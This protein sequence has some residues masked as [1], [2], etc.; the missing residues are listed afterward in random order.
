M[1][2]L[3]KVKKADEENA[4]QTE[5]GKNLYLDRKY[6][7]ES[8]KSIVNI[9]EISRYQNPKNNL[10]DPTWRE[11]SI[12]STAIFTSP[13]HKIRSIVSNSAN[14]VFSISAT[15]GVFGDLTTSYDMGYLEDKL[16]YES[17]E[18]AFKTMVESEISLCGEIRKYRQQKRQITVDFFSEDSASFPNDKTKEVATRFESLILK[19]FIRYLKQEQNIPYFNS[20]NCLLYT[21]PSPRDGLLSRMPS[22]A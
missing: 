10:I 17:G 15:G 18:S 21:S 11:V 7:Y 22:S 4:T 8:N 20:Y 1:T 2:Y 3:S 6:V 9:K 12:G 5:R 13:E 14:V 16:R 19:D